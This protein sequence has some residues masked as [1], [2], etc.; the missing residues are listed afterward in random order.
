ME[1]QYA[2]FFSDAH[3][4]SIDL[5]CQSSG[6]LAVATLLDSLSPE[7]Q[8][9]IMESFA[10]HTRDS[11]ARIAQLNQAGQR[12]EESLRQSRLEEQSSAAT[13][14]SMTAA[15]RSSGPSQL[16]ARPVKLKVTKYGGGET[17][18][19]LHWIFQVQASADALL[20]SDE[21]VRIHFAV[22]HLKD[23]AQHWAYSLLSSDTSL[24]SR[25]SSPN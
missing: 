16:P 23:R 3:R 8:I 24:L 20:I 25:H 10:L 4:A 6:D 2:E 7:R 22:S 18:K 9:Q 1:R 11:E 17:E 14:A 21:V 15:M 5:M 19:L 13:V 12:L